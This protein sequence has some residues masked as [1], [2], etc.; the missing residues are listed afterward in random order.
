ML[1]LQEL[2]LSQPSHEYRQAFDLA[3]D[4][5]NMA[6][7]KALCTLS[8]AFHAVELL[9]RSPRSSEI[10]GTGSFDVCGFISAAADWAWGELRARTPLLG[11]HQAVNGALAT[12]VLQYLP[13]FLRPDA[14]AVLSGLEQVEYHGRD[15]IVF[16]RGHTWLFDVA[17][18][19]AGILSLVDT[20]DRLELPR[21][22]VALVGVLGDK[23]WEA[24][25]PPLFSRMDG[26]VLTQPPSAPAE[27]RW[28][29]E[30][31][32]ATVATVTRKE[33]V[34]DFVAAVARAESWAGGGT[35]VV[36]GSVHTVG[37]TLNLLGLEPLRGR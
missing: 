6:E 12:E 17:H 3:A 4:Y 11:H 27:R 29:P 1:D 2:Y 14:R 23:Q 20:I 19:T 31:A 28:D 37:S 32:A 10:V 22:I 33:V 26:V 7:G 35:V 5:L 18:N 21:P 30:V 24:M 16:Q 25:L 9:K 8:S 15:E 36:T 34:E 13:D